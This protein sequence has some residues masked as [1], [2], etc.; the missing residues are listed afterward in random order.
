MEINKDFS[1]CGYEDSLSA[2]EDGLGHIEIPFGIN[3]RSHGST[4]S[5]PEISGVYAF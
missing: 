1:K 2:V 4:G 3:A 5:H